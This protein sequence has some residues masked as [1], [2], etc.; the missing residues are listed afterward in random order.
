MK[1]GTTAAVGVTRHA[2]LTIAGRPCR[3]PARIREAFA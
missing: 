2:A 1:D 3:L